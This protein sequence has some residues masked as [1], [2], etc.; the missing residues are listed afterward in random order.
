MNVKAKENLRSN[1]GNTEFSF[2]KDELTLR[3]YFMFL[4][5]QLSKKQLRALDMQFPTVQGAM[6]VAA[7]YAH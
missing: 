3:S 4:K 5:T 6:C 1:K 2:I 7:V